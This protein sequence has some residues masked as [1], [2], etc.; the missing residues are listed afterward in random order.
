MSGHNKLCKVEKIIIIFYIINSL[1]PFFYEYWKQRT[2]NLK[3]T[4]ST[5]I[6]L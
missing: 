2:N 6:N 3:L 4:S 5:D 1:I